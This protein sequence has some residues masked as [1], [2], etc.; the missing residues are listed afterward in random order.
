MV[1]DQ[2]PGLGESGSVVALPFAVSR[3]IGNLFK[4][5]SSEL[6]GNG[7]RCELGSMQGS[8]W[9]KHSVSS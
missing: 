4:I 1:P 9:V 3:L 7:D 6:N 2:G 8:F 5:P